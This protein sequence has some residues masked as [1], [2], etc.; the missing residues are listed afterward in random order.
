MNDTRLYEQIFGI[1]APWSVQAVD[2]QLADGQ[3][4]ITVE[5][6][7]DGEVCPECGTRCS[8]YDR[9]KRRWRHLDTCQYQTIVIAAVPR[10]RCAE[11]GVLWYSDFAR[12]MAG[13]RMDFDRFIASN[14]SESE[15]YH[16]HEQHRW[17]DDYGTCCYYFSFWIAEALDYSLSAPPVIAAAK[18]NFFLYQYYTL[19]DD[20]LDE[21]T[22]SSEL[23]AFGGDLLL[24]RSLE[25]FA[26]TGVSAATL[27]ARFAECLTVATT[28]ERRLRNL[29]STS[30]AADFNIALSGQKAALAKLPAY[31]LAVTP[32]QQAKLPGVELAMDRLAVALQLIDDLLDW[33]QDCPGSAGM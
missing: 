31:A 21:G 24:A 17:Q 19:R 6:S 9:N 11:H 4:M 29:N 20:A 30:T 13:V 15:T 16:T 23:A 2:L 33:R 14:L 12:Q 5:V 27:L 22:I 3:V 18:G 25:S 10:V 8:R 7:S 26:Q 32:D 1:T 28:A